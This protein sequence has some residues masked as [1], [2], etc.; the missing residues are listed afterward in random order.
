M[1][2]SLSA[3]MHAAV[4]AYFAAAGAAAGAA[5]AYPEFAAPAEPSSIRDV[6]FILLLDMQWGS[7]SIAPVNEGAAIVKSSDASLKMYPAVEP[8]CDAD[9]AM[10]CLKLAKGQ[11]VAVMAWSM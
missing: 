5:A 8:L 7:Q 11:Q 2:S 4:A 3:D 6:F 10:K 1:A 9:L